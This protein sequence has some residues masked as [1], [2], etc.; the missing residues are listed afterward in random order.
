MNPSLRESFLVPEP[1]FTPIPFWFW[2]DALREPEIKRQMMDFKRKGIHAFVI[3][4]RIGLPA[5]L[6]YMSEQW[7]EIVGYAAR[8][9]SLLDMQVVL[10]D[11]GMYPSGS[12]HGMVVN[13][14]S[15]YRSRGLRRVT[16]SRDISASDTIVYHQDEISYVEGPT[17]GTIRGIH[18]GEDDG[19]PGA[20]PSAD[21]LNPDA[22]KL[23]ITLTHDKYYDALRQYFGSTVIGMFTDE[24][25]ITGRNVEKEILPWGAGFLDYFIKQGGKTSDIPKFWLPGAERKLYRKAINARLGEVYYKPISQWCESRNIALMGHPEKSSDIALQKYFH[26]PGQDLVLRFVSPEGGTALHREHSTQA[27]CSADAARHAGRRRNSNEC[28]GACNRDG[29]PWNFTGADMKWYID[30]LCVRGVNMLIPHAFY[31]SVEGQRKFE[32]PPDVGPNNIWWDN[33]KIISDY[34]KRL[35]WLMTGSANTAS[36]AVLCGD[37][38]LDWQETAALFQNQVEFNYVEEKY[39]VSE[40]MA[41]GCICIQENRYNILL[42]PED[43]E[44]SDEKSSLLIKSGVKIVSTANEVLQFA[45]RSVL[46]AQFEPDLRFSHV[47]KR[48]HDFYFFVNEG[49]TPIKTTTRIFRRGRC[50]LWYP[51]EGKITEAEVTGVTEDS[52]SV[53]LHLPRR[54]SVILRVDENEEPTKFIEKM[55]SVNIADVVGGKFFVS[56]MKGFDK[57]VLNLGAGYEYAEAYVNEKQAGIKMWAPHSFDITDFVIA[58]E[59]SVQVMTKDCKVYDY[60]ENLTKSAKSQTWTV[61][62]FSAIATVTEDVSRC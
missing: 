10:Y 61:E 58:G 25:C 49:E 1:E 46:C 35:C 45:T 39:L 42:V 6:P 48:N 23:F 18:F 41:D 21:L 44:I 32:R 30:W 8:E 3:H 27:K 40:N 51:F 47:R 52:V 31:Y 36:V 19:E 16:D 17:G 54:E 38:I 4:P 62:F 59:N 60:A 34:M 56:S 12:A 28:F 55:A 43:T 11:E 50:E 14:N 24:P 33:Y 15:D 22:I 5:D 57:A 20:P 2:N 26:V 9:A 7:L 37:D 13:A 53:S 29:V